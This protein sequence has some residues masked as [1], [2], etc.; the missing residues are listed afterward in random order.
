MI[1]KRHPLVEEATD[2]TVD[3]LLKAIAAPGS[4]A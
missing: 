3:I 2:A 1:A 4:T